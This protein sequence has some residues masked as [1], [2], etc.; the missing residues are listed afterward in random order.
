ME[1]A[2]MEVTGSSTS[3][4]LVVGCGAVGRLTNDSGLLNHRASIMYPLFYVL[5]LPFDDVLHSATEEPK[6]ETSEF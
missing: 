1:K 5:L 6:V 2:R 3:M 4:W